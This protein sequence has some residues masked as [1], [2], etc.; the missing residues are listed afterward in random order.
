[1][2][3]GRRWQNPKEQVR[4]SL[5]PF[6]P[7]I[8]A[9]ATLSARNVAGSQH[10]ALISRLILSQCKSSLQPTFQLSE[11]HQKE[12]AKIM[13][14][15]IPQPVTMHWSSRKKELFFVTHV[16]EMPSS[17]LILHK[18]ETLAEDDFPTQ[19]T[20]TLWPKAFEQHFSFLATIWQLYI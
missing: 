3:R 7:E 14:W 10:S 20:V 9:K 4:L 2:N 17:C 8:A 16:S 11:S 19:R 6:L 15:Q 5:T 18:A 12:A 13:T 1:M